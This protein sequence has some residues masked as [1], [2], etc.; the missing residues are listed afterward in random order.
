MKECKLFVADIAYNTPLKDVIR[1]F[2]QFGSNIRIQRQISNSK[3]MNY[4]RG[5]RIQDNH[6][7]LEIR[8]KKIYEIILITENLQISQI[9]GRSLMCEPFLTDLDLNR[10]NAKNNKKRDIVKY[11]PPCITSNAVKN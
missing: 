10:S 9:S 4:A 6:C 7:M 11:V 5:S 1:Y 3:T 2:S 8:D